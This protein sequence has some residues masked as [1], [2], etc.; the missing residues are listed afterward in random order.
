MAQSTYDFSYG[1][2]FFTSSFPIIGT[3]NSMP[4]WIDGGVVDSSK[5]QG[6]TREY[7]Q[8]DLFRGNYNTFWVI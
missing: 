6:I 5:N 3:H 8:A 1:V 2:E 7:V 4:A